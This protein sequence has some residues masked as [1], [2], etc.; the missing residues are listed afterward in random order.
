DPGRVGRIVEVHPDVVQRLVEGGFI[1]V[2]APVAVD[3]AGRSL[4]VNADTVAGRIAEALRAKKLVLMTDIEGVKGADGT[5]VSSLNPRGARELEEKGVIAGGMIP[6]V[7]C[8]LNAVQRGVQKAHIIDGRN[9]HAMLLEIFTD[10][11]VGT[12]LTNS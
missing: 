7:R 2:I 8:A 11:G 6:K 3:D 4:N 10:E 5:V 1:P 12:E 9:Q